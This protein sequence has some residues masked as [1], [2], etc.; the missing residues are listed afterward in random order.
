LAVAL[1][2]ASQDD[3]EYQK[4]HEF[5]KYIKRCLKNQ[6]VFRSVLRGPP[7]VIARPYPK[8][9]QDQTDLDQSRYTNNLAAYAIFKGY[10]IAH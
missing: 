5:G 3:A 9:A 7:K 10:V 1:D 4:W 6:E 2:S 8:E